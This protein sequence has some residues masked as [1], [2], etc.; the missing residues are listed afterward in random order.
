MSVLE[1]ALVGVSACSH[2][3]EGTCCFNLRYFK[4]SAQAVSV[5]LFLPLQCWLLTLPRSLR[6]GRT[7]GFVIGGHCDCSDLE[8]DGWLTAQIHRSG[9][10]DTKPYLNV[11]QLSWVQAGIF[12][13]SGGD[14]GLLFIHCSV[15]SMHWSREYKEKVEIAGSNYYPPQC[16]DGFGDGEPHQLQRLTPETRAHVRGRKGNEAFIQQIKEMQL[17]VEAES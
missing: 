3:L 15:I 12:H 4:F 9:A 16:S 14:M 13:F 2:F 5:V 17:S 6:L 1:C 10:G 11:F 7:A 8:E